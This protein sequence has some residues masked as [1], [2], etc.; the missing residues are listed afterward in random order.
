MKLKVLTQNGP[1]G[2]E[3][4]SPPWYNTQLFI[5]WMFLL[6]Y[7]LRT[8]RTWMFNMNG[9]ML[10]GEHKEEAVESPKRTGVNRRRMFCCTTPPN[11]PQFENVLVL[12]VLAIS[13]N[14]AGVPPSVIIIT[15]PNSQPA[16]DGCGSIQFLRKEWMQKHLRRLD[17]SPQFM[18]A[19]TKGWDQA[20]TLHLRL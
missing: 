11:R 8:V 6:H 7:P 9:W 3:L 16:I 18:E 10:S 17:T 12:E 14:G 5:K 19:V 13:S 1:A 4:D 20:G 15:T 2:N